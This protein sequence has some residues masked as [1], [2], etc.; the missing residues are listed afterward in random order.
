MAAAAAAA[1]AAAGSSAAS[2]VIPAAISAGGGIVGSI[3]SKIAADDNLK[4]AQQFNSD[5]RARQDTYMQR[6]VADFTAAGFSPLAALEGAGNYSSVAS[7]PFVD[8]SYT[9]P[10]ANG[11]NQASQNLLQALGVN[12]SFAA[13]KMKVNEEKRYHDMVDSID[14]QRLTNEQNNFLTE[15]DKRVEL[16]KM[17]NQNSKDIAQI[18]ADAQ[19]SI[20]RVKN[21]YDDLH[22]SETQ[23][24]MMKQFDA[25]QEQAWEMARK[26]RNQA[27]RQFWVNTAVNVAT[28]AAELFMQQQQITI[29]KNYQSYYGIGSD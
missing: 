29:N 4:Y 27:E 16:A 6:R 7:V 12:S 11:L 25:Q 2:Y 10:L 24:L 19:K 26:A 21:Q 20:A 23:K 22:F 3:L 15:L 8:S 14:R 9:Q 28:K 13:E 17:A 18:S 1:G 5:E